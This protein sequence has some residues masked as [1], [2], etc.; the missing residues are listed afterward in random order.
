VTSVLTPPESV[1]LLKDRTATRRKRL[2]VKGQAVEY[3]VVPCDGVAMI[4]ASA[5]LAEEKAG[6]RPL[7]APA[8]G[9]WLPTAVADLIL[10]RVLCSTAVCGRIFWTTEWKPKEQKPQKK[11]HVIAGSPLVT[12]TAW[13]ILTSEGYE[14][15]P[16]AS[17]WQREDPVG[18]LHDAKERAERFWDNPRC[19]ACNTG[20][21]RDAEH[22]WRDGQARCGGCDLAMDLVDFM[23]RG[24]T[25]REIEAHL[26]RRR[27]TFRR[28]RDLIE[29]AL[30]RAGAMK[31]PSGIWMT[32]SAEEDVA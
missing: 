26:R 3:V 4:F 25:E 22:W 9:W 11:A 13:R 30:A 19:T 21:T 15:D 20:I 24:R 1:K 5:D 28:R 8:S 32:K 7:I 6:G 23:T 12:E 16:S 31:L 27:L 29:E 14:Y 2:V 10:Y 17:P 18:V